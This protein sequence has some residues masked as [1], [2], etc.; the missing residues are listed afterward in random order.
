ML[1]VEKNVFL[2]N[3]NISV[4]LFIN[5]FKTVDFY[6]RYYM[7]NRFEVNGRELLIYDFKGNSRNS[8]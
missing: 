4:L 8:G 1:H 2:I 7:T 5:V 3:K 6:F